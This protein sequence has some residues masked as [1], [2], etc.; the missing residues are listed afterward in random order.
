LRKTGPKDIPQ[1]VNKHI[2]VY[3]RIDPSY[4]PLVPYGTVWNEVL[5]SIEYRLATKWKWEE[6]N[7]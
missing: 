4:P 2:H 5:V 1:E 6:N 3:K 7:L